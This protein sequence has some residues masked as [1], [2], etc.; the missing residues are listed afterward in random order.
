MRVRLKDGLMIV[1]P[2]SETERH[3]L[4]LWSAG[5]DRHMLGLRVQGDGTL[6]LQDAGPEVEVRSQP[7][8]ITWDAAPPPLNLIANLA[9]TPFELDG[10]RYASVEGFWQ[11]LK[12][13]EGAERDRVAALAGHEAKT[14]GGALPYGDLVR[15]SGRDARVG[16][17]E[18]WA[19]MEAACRAKFAQHAPARDALVSTA[20]RPIEHKVRVDSRTIPGVVMADIWVRIRRDLAAREP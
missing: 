1:S 13:P 15:Y 9:P 3:E 11:G 16:T 7:I 12:F 5:R 8:N 20:G 6:R 4:A 2:E 14:A 17:V 19:L 18:H 10:R